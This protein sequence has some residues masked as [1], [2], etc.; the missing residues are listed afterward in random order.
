MGK[1]EANKGTTFNEIV[2]GLWVEKTGIACCNI[3][4]KREKTQL[5]RKNNN[6]DLTSH[7]LEILS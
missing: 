3:D 4:D 7:T 6:H 5:H 1:Q 2:N